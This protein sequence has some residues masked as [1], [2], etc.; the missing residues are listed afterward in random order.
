MGPRTARALVALAL[1]VPVA[2]WASGG[3]ETSAAAGPVKLKIF[4]Q[5]PTSFVQENNQ[6]IAYMEK[7]LNLDLEYEIPPLESYGE[8]QRIVLASANTRTS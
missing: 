8:R 4:Q 6:V 3:T 5:F 7:K 2:L 1:M